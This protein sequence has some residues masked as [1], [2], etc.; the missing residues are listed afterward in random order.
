MPSG[1]RWE[2]GVQHGEDL[3]KHQKKSRPTSALRGKREKK[4]ENQKQKTEGWKR[5]PDNCLPSLSL[6]KE[7]E[8]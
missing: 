3:K 2:D 1:I 4:N 6:L 8:A 7:R 5:E